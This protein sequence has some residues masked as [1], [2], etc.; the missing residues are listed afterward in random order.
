MGI[1]W[2]TSPSLQLCICRQMAFCVWGAGGLA[3]FCKDVI[4]IGL[5]PSPLWYGLTSC[6]QI[7]F[8]MTLFPHKVTFWG[9]RTYDCG[10]SFAFSGG[11][12]STRIIGQ[13]SFCFCQPRGWAPLV[14]WPPPSFP[15]PSPVSLRQIVRFQLLNLQGNE[16]SRIL[17]R[18][19]AI[20]YVR[21]SK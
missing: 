7:T 2:L 11:H 1:P 5:R 3:S 8:A 19:P 12:N 9:T 4:H 18:I 16:V 17:V 15:L 20:L 21:W 10:I 14:A 13:T 6:W